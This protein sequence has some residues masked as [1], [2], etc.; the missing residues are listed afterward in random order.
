MITAT[1]SAS[2]EWPTP[3]DVFA[4]LGAHFGPF[5]LDPASTDENRKA[6]HNFTPQI[7]G[8]S[9]PWHGR[10][11]LNPPYGRT[12]SQGR[13]IGDWMR[14]AAQEAREGRAELV[15]AL[16]PCRPDT[17]WYRD[18]VTSAALVRVWPGRIRFGPN[19]APFPSAVVVFG[20][21][22]ARH[23]AEISKCA[24][25]HGLYWPRRATAKTC[26]PKCRTQKWRQEKAA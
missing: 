8:L 15:C 5:D 13:S 4:F 19:P 21:L 17:A 12:D 16:V 11:W 10:V 7:D 3:P 1:S 9:Q 24:V 20:T 25:C 22:P 14:K 2:A 23:Y 26:S 18:A 6:L